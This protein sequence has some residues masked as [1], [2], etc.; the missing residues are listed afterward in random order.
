[1][2]AGITV[3]LVRVDGTVNVAGT[4]LRVAPGG[5][6][7]ASGALGDEMLNGIRTPVLETS[8]ADLL[9][10]VSTEREL[11]DFAA[12]LPVARLVE[13]EGDDLHEDWMD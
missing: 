13:D 6:R 4:R 5:D 2:T 10:A 1:M 11:R 9:A 8:R 7:Y 12:S 3:R